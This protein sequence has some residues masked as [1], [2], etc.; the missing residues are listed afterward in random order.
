MISPSSILRLHL[1][2]EAVWRL[3]RLSKG[4]IYMHMDKLLIELTDLR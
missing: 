3:Q 4:P 2:P 1:T